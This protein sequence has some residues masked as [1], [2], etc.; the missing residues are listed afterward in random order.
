[1][2]KIGGGLGWGSI[3]KIGTSTI[4]ATVEASNFKFST[5]IVFGA[6]LPKKRRLGPK[7]AGVWAREAH[8]KIGT[9]YV[10]L[11]TVEASDWKIGIQ[12]E[13]RFTLPNTSFR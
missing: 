4:S 3:Q 11:A 5:Q 6:S 10:F 8:K 2:T 7:L 13:F 9:P 12:H 1:M